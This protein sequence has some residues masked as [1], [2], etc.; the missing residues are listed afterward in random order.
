MIERKVLIPI[1]IIFVL[2]MLNLATE[3]FIVGRGRHG[4]LNLGSNKGIL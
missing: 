2:V 1:Q 3:S 4:N